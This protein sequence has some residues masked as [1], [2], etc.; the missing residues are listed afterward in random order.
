MRQEQ[1]DILSDID[2]ECSKLE[3]ILHG[4]EGD[5]IT[6]IRTLIIKLQQQDILSREE[7]WWIFKIKHNESGWTI[8]WDRM[9]YPSHEF[10]DKYVRVYGTDISIYIP[11]TIGECNKEELNI[12]NKL[13]ESNTRV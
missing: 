3:D 8:P 1:L 5:I 7:R 10:F 4:E 12:I 13:R 11:R 9:A 6:H 2:F